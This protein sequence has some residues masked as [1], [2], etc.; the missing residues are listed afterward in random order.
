MNF[1]KKTPQVPVEPVV[2]VE[3]DDTKEFLDRIA[4]KMIEKGALPLIPNQTI[5]KSIQEREEAAYSGAVETHQ[6][7]TDEQKAAEE[8]RITPAQQLNIAVLDRQI[9]E[10]EHRG[11]RKG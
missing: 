8:G 9:A 4:E 11:E 6:Y 5:D 2:P 3:D 10:R 1:F 7:L